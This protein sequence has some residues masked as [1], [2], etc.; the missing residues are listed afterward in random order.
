MWSNSRRN[1]RIDKNSFITL[2]EANWHNTLTEMERDAK[3][4]FTLAA[5]GG[6]HFFENRNALHPGKEHTVDVGVNATYKGF[7]L[8]LGL[9][10]PLNRMEK[11][12]ASLSLGWEM[13]KMFGEKYD[14]ANADLQVD[15]S[16][17]T[18]KDA[19]STYKTTLTERQQKRNSLL[20]KIDMQIEQL[21]VFYDYMNE[22]ENWFKR[23]LITEKQL[24]QARRDWQNAVASVVACRI[25][26]IIYNLETADYF[27]PQ[28]GKVE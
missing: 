11:S 14:F 24:L 13:S 2:E 4:Q 16:K 5:T 21:K 17:I 18:V 6:Y 15:I 27:L 1:Y 7:N 19:I 10:M 20:A 28:R 26:G 3:K 23:G 25:E 8:G 12:G 22:S 9:S